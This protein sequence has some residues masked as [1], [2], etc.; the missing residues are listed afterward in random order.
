MSFNGE[1]RERERERGNT[2]APIEK[3]GPFVGRREPVS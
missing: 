2:G 1:E 3:S